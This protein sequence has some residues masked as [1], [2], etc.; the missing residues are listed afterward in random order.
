PSSWG[1]VA[2]ARFRST[3]MT[4]RAPISTRTIPMTCHR[5]RRLVS[6]K[7]GGAL[8]RGSRRN[9]L[10]LLLAAASGCNPT[11]VAAPSGADKPTEPPAVTL[12]RPVRQTLRRTVE[13][14]G[15]IEAFEQTPLYAKVT[16]Y[17]RAVHK[18]I[19]D[20]IRKDDV[21]ADLWVPE[22]AEE[23]QLKDAQTALA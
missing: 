17:V 3:R 4:G 16:G 14:P 10:V 7:L 9:A 5:P 2:P 13:Q 8:A 22:L 1:G 15:R 18:D 12:V 11:S 19:G 6:A 21:L 20:R 23:L